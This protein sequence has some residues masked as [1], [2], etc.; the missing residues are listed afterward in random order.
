[1]GS[2][3]QAQ[4]AI[5]D[6]LNKTNQGKGT[7]IIHQPLSVSQLVGSLPPDTRIEE[8]NGMRFIIAPGYR[9]QVFSGNN[10][11]KSK[12]E[13]FAKQTQINHLYPDLTTYVSYSAPFWKLRVGD[14][15][16]YE[17]A[18]STKYKLGETFPSFKSEINVFK[19]EIRIPIN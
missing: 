19:E 13:A 9:L 7:V 4:T 18:L 15:I 16:T 8:D 11:R 14:F 10:Q 2:I 1:M 6:A 5:F 3:M 17:E 12:D